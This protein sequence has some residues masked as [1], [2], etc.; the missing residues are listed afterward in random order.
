[1]VIAPVPQPMSRI[2]LGEVT[3]EWNGLL[4]IR[5]IREADWPS[6]RSCSVA[7]GGALDGCV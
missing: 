1:M 5:A 2:L 6:R 7:L 3:G 4:F